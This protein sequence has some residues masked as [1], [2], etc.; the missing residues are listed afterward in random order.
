MSSQ[1]G[2]RDETCPF[3]TGRGGMQH[4]GAHLVSDGA[5]WQHS[6][7]SRNSAAARK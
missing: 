7:A 1:Y 5:V 4:R 2:R 3:S 6:V